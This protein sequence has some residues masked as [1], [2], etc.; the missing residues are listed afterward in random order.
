VVGF[1]MYGVED[2]V[3]FRD[4]LIL[5]VLFEQAFFK[6]SRLAIAWRSFI[7][8]GDLLSDALCSARYL[9]PSLVSP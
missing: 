4:V 2:G 3:E 6:A 8:S 7:V 5:Y 9:A 1:G